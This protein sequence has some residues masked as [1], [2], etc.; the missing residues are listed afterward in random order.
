MVRTRTKD[1]G[2]D[3]NHNHNSISYDD[4]LETSD[5]DDISS[6]FSTRMNISTSHNKE[7]KS[8][9]ESNKKEAVK[10]FKFYL[11]RMDQLIRDRAFSTQSFDKYPEYM[12]TIYNLFDTVIDNEY[13]LIPSKEQSKF[14]KVC[15]DKLYHIIERLFVT[16]KRADLA[17]SIYYHYEDFYNISYKKCFLLEDN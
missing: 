3:L 6:Q 15:C 13:Y 17:Y 10:L 7:S 12:N 16:F 9:F 14:Y 5:E 2:Y 4:N 11:D 1:Y 8:E